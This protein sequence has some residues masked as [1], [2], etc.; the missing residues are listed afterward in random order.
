MK[1][2]SR[3]EKHSD[4][5]GHL[6]SS[7][8]LRR[9][10]SRNTRFT[11]W[12][13]AVYSV[14]LLAL[15]SV[16]LADPIEVRSRS[17]LEVETTSQ[18]RLLRVRARVEDDAG[19]PLSQVPVRVALI[20]RSGERLELVA[21]TD[22]AGRARFNEV[23]EEDDW[24]VRVTWDG[25]G[26][27]D[28][29]TEEQTLTIRQSTVAFDGPQQMFL[30]QTEQAAE[31]TW[32][33]LVDDQPVDLGVWVAT[34]DCMEVLPSEGA[35]TSNGVISL[36]VRRLP[37][38]VNAGC[39][40]RLTMAAGDWWLG[41]ALSVPLT[42]L[43]ASTTLGVEVEAE[44]AVSWL[45]DTWLV[46]PSASTTDGPLGLGVIEVWH[47]DTWVGD[48]QPGI[49]TDPLRW[50]PDGRP[51]GS[52]ELRLLDDAGQV[53]ARSLVEIPVPADPFA[54]MPW[55]LGASAGVI[56]LAWLIRSG[57]PGWLVPRPGG[58]S[59]RRPQTAQAGV[60]VRVEPAYGRP[61]RIV[62]EDSHTG[63]RIDAT[64]SVREPDSAEFHVLHTDT[65]PWRTSPKV[66]IRVFA[67][68]YAALSVEVSRP[69]AGEIVVVALTENRR[70][71]LATFTETL[72]LIGAQRVQ[73]DWWGKR[74]PSEFLGPAM[75]VVRGLREPSAVSD[76]RRRR[77][78]ELQSIDP[79]TL[80]P[81]DALEALFLLVDEV[82]FG[83]PAPVSET[84]VGRAEQLAERALSRLQ[85]VGRQPARTA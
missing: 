49:D 59:G 80:D 74:S 46:T 29:V 50:M 34:S 61:S 20:R 43:P 67:E 18:G 85:P 21:L 81:V 8:T 2:A 30:G 55:V 14:L 48:F 47:E 41:G 12:T 9:E 10:C 36:S 58:E 16:A 57:L 72:G 68:G 23:L 79:G 38:S 75:D 13:A 65:D 52:L 66:E 26:A 60:A 82:C 6:A 69:S 17:Q 11:S 84:A 15:P 31:L 37:G 40:M 3:L 62:V 33:A 71:V 51:E 27:V 64:V 4:R 42:E 56:V 25:R 35:T 1:V 76:V 22:R 7:K 45:A 78:N 28:P 5:F 77:F 24:T 39:D 19:Q 83:T 73:S 32:R 63:H 70:L 44:G 54:W 53:V